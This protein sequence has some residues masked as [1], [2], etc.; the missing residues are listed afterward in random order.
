MVNI[1]TTDF[2][3]GIT[4]MS[5]DVF[6][7]YSTKLFDE[8]EAY[9]ENILKLP[10]Y[11]LVLD[12]E[13]G[14]VK[15]VGKIATTL[16]ALYFGI[17]SYGSFVSGLNT[18]HEQ[19]RTVGDYLGERA[20]LPFES[21]AIKPKVTKHGDS[22]SSLQRLF[23]KVQ[24]GKMTVEEAMLESEKLFGNETQ[25][26]PKFMNE[27]HESLKQTPSLSQQ[28]Q[29]PLDTL[30]QEELLSDNKKP[31]KPRP[32][33]PNKRLVDPQLF[34]IEV[35]RESKKGKRNVRVTKL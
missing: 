28:I 35:W 30:G 19:V 2:Y 11:S 22:L 5:P 33:Q 17:A 29:L 27:L 12:V 14:S 6:E 9:I 4:P 34:R 7:K 13:E 18:I 10:D 24:R 8:W 15:A 26:S 16:G 3:I 21:Q 20:A 23:I 32:S 1:G 25:T 31:R